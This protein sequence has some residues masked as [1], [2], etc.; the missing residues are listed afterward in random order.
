MKP[1]E[2]G[3]GSDGPRDALAL[4][5]AAGGGDPLSDICPLQY[6]LPAAPQ[7]AARHAGPSDAEAVMQRIAR[8]YE[9]LAAEHTAV[10]VEGAGGLLVPVAEGL[11]MGD[12]ARRLALPLIV[13]ARASLGTINHT[14]LTLEV[15]RQRRLEIAGVVVS[16]TVRISE[17]D[18]EN[19][20]FLRDALGELLV[21]EIPYLAETEP[22]EFPT[23]DLEAW[24]RLPT[25]NGRNG[26][27]GRETN[28]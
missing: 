3:V 26:R 21:A 18:E 5:E 23:A 4:R 12:L 2:T 20:T 11:D 10:V 1:V 24:L 22:L 28:R 27:N 15:A 14:L 13:V 19:L 16:H 25:R 17:A 7:V 6:A 8:A 9:R